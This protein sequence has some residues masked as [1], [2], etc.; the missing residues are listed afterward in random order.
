MI[1]KSEDFK[2]A[3]S[4]VRER[5]ATAKRHGTRKGFIDYHGCLSVTHD[6]ICILEDADKIAELGEY[7]FAYSVAALILINLA[8]LADTADDSAGG[9]TD[10]RGYVDDVLQKVC[11]CAKYDSRNADYIFLQ[12]IKDSQNKA[13]EGSY[14]FAYDLLLNTACL[15]TKDNKNKMYDAL[16]NLYSKI[17]E[18]SF[19]LW[20]GELDAIVRLEI[21]KATD[22]EADVA[23][24][25][26]A[27]LKYDAVRRVAVN[28]AIA[29][30][31]Y[32]HAE[33]LCFEKLTPGKDT[34]GYSQQ[35]EWRYLLFEIYDKS[36]DTEKKIRI[37]EDLL[38][39]FETKYY[40]ILKQMLIEKGVW[41]SKYPLLLNQLEQRLPYH[42]FMKILSD[43]GEIGRLLEEIRK[44][45]SSVFDYGQQLVV[46]FP[47]ETYSLC[48]YEVHRQAREAN[49]RTEY[50]K[51]CRLIKKL[52]D[53]GGADEAKRIIAELKL[54]YPR[55]PAFLE[56]LDALA[57]RLTKKRK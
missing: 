43:E 17:G 16:N 18:T 57:V 22:D 44:H 49:N 38:F 21:I 54:Q 19:S 7:T 51:V 8:K 50:K 33:K 1:A 24:F 40:G 5:I 29:A 42:L 52:F 53:I 46:E 55:R 4:T 13:F 39:N 2:T 20:A 32:L 10:T 14:E 28:N 37:T 34:N 23:D 9:I 30:D 12:S 47:I 31:N 35:S 48:A 15:A 26:N 41:D 25:I 56:E 45:S 36:G 6:F 3:L 27:N 11:S